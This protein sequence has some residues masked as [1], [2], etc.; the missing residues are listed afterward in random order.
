MPEIEKTAQT[1]ETTAVAK[2][3]AEVEA[4]KLAE[5]SKG[6]PK[7]T[8]EEN[9]EQARRRRQED[10]K[11]ALEKRELDTA[12]K[13]TGGKNPF[14]GEKIEDQADLDELYL[15]K[16]IEASGGDPVADYAKTLKKKQKE[17]KAVVKTETMTKEQAKNDWQ[18][19]ETAY[20]GITLKALQDDMDFLDYA[21]GKIGNRPLAKIYE[22]Y[23][24]LKGKPV[25]KVVKPSPGPLNTEAPANSE[26]YSMEQ[27]DKFTAAQ[28]HA[29]S[30]KE[31]EKVQK[32]KAHWAKK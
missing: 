25:E 5:L 2:T 8:D 11:K 32:S 7:Q 13:L 10:E 18:A 19:F 1:T 21:E 12:I 31:F 24:K 17:E 28:L 30:A 6:K 26:Y 3:E 14:T 29:M 27:I 22:G 15:M 16:E 4:E 23:L 20:P 9:A